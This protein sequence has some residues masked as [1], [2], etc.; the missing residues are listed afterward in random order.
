M[1]NEPLNFRLLVFNKPMN[2]LTRF[3]DDNGRGTL[4]GFIDVPDVYP[5][6]RLDLNSEGLLLLTDRGSLVEPLLQPGGKEK[7]YLV[8][9]EGEATPEQLEALSR[10]PKLKDGQCRPARVRRLKAEPDW[11]WPRNPPI[12]F[13]KSI[14][15]SWL[16]I[17]ITEGRNRQVR[18]MTAAVGL[19]TL[20]LVRLR[21]AQFSLSPDL[22]PGQWREATQQEKEEALCLEY[23][24]A[25]SEQSVTARR[26]KARGASSKRTPP[27]TKGRR[28]RGRRGPGPGR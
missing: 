15:V 3:T 11:L 17:V 19:P 23:D 12:R 25:R 1:P 28:R 14:P 20:R 9:V 26:R 8:C 21:F 18:R 7:E 16:S 13:R 22:S 27:S 24:F 4:A 6:G 5:I 2:V 10:G